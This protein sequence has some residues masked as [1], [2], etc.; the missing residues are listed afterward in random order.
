LVVKNEFQENILEHVYVSDPS[1]SFR[2]ALARVIVLAA[3]E[4]TRHYDPIKAIQ[5]PCS[6][7]LVRIGRGDSDNRFSQV[8]SFKN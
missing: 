1:S 2:A 4:M 8:R 3:D 7:I 5:K 6:K